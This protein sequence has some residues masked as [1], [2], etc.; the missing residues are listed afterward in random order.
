MNKK[1][2]VVELFACVGGFRV[3]LEKADKELFHTVWGNQWEPSKKVQDAFDC[4]NTHFP[5][6]I[7]C[8]DDV[9]KVA[10]K[11]F[12]DMNI[13]LLVGGFL[14]GQVNRLK[15]I[16]RMLY[17]RASFPLLRLRMLYQP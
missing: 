11:K 6:S 17:G 10:N 12:E 14:E 15:T 9:G 5:S 13:D 2:N 7:N 16:K 4:Y 1:I 8:N 3:G